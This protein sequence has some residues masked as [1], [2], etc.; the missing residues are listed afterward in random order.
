LPPLMP[1]NGGLPPELARSCILHFSFL[2]SHFSFLG[3]F[4]RFPALT[5]TEPPTPRPAWLRLVRGVTACAS[6]PIPA[7]P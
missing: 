1:A 3:L 5:L 6:S 7:G 2:I 4:N